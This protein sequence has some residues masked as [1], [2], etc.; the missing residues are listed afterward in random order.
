MERIPRTAAAAIA[1]AIA[2]AIGLGPASTDADA[3]LSPPAPATSANAAAG[4]GSVLRALAPSHALRS[5][6]VRLSVTVPQARPGGRVR[7][8]SRALG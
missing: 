3:A 1:I 4:Q 6:R 2:A 7:V 5:G 8:A